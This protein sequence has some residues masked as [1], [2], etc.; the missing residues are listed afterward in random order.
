MLSFI[1]KGFNN[2]IIFDVVI[3]LSLKGR[4]NLEQR[5]TSFNSVVIALSLKGRHN[6]F[7][8]MLIVSKLLL[9]LV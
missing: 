3:A 2:R 9:L 5:C 7:V 8:L 6:I 4:H 1:V